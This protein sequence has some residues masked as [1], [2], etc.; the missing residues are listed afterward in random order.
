MDGAGP[1]RSSSIRYYLVGDQHRGAVQPSC[2]S[3]AADQYLWPLLVTTRD[4]M[5]TIVYIG[6]KKIIDVHDALTSRVGER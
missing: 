1:I 2:S 6:I 5:Q 3:T 4:D